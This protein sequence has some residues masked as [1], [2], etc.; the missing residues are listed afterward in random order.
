M[1]CSISRPSAPSIVW[2]R[3]SFIRRSGTQ[4]VNRL[5]AYISARTGP[6]DTIFNLGR[7]SQIYFYADRRPAVRYFYDYVYDYDETAL[8]VTLEALRQTKPVYIID[9]LQPPLFEPTE[10]KPDELAALLSHDYV[11]EGRI[12]FSDVYRLKAGR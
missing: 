8:P 10:K 1:P 5:V 3:P 2:R 7:Q 6:E 9:S 12:F 4:P 11:Y